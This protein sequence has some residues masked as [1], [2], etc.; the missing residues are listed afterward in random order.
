MNV[1]KSRMRPRDIR[2]VLMSC[3]LKAEV[4]ERITVGEFWSSECQKTRGK[5]REYNR[6]GTLMEVAGGGLPIIQRGV[7]EES[8]NRSALPDG[9]RFVATC[10][11]EPD[12]LY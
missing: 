4:E 1:T 7:C 12:T 8:R 6:R 3:T 2:A 11:L 5:Q 9:P 10:N